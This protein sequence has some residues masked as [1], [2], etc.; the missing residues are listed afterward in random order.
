MEEDLRVLAEHVV[1]D[2]I[3]AYQHNWNSARYDHHV[4]G[5]MNLFV[6][7]R[8]KKQRP[9]RTKP[10]QPEMDADVF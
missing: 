3:T 2:I 10:F 4:T 1:S 9:V 5:L 6:S 7:I 8:D